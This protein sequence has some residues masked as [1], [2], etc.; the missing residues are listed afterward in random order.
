PRSDEDRRNRLLRRVR[1]GHPLSILLVEPDRNPDPAQREEGKNRVDEKNAP[2]QIRTTEEP[3][4]PDR[5]QQGCAGRDTDPQVDRFSESEETPRV[6]TKPEGPQHAQLGRQDR[7]K[8]ARTA[9]HEL[10]RRLPVEAEEDREGKARNQDE[11]VQHEL[12]RFSCDRL[13]HGR[14]RRITPSPS[15]LPSAPVVSSVPSYRS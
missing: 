4:K 12:R 9:L 8:R 3:N 13:P 11:H 14:L 6:A 15:A 7:G 1:R 10:R 2:G 5:R